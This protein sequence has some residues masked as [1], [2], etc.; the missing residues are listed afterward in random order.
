MKIT[1][2][3]D[4]VETLNWTTTIIKQKQNQPICYVGTKLLMTGSCFA[5]LYPAHRGYKTQAGIAGVGGDIYCWT[6]SWVT[7][8][9]KKFDMLCGHDQN[10]QM[11]EL[12][13]R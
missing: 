13:A 4:M 6:I 11:T 9:R 7:S 10:D 3:I 12:I 1:N 8:S 2:T 5:P